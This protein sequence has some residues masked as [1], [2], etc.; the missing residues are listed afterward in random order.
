MVK[1]E[2]TEQEAKNV[3]LCLNYDVAMCEGKHK[4]IIA[5]AIKK[6]EKAILYGVDEP[7]Q[8]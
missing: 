3:L 1:I 4:R 7:E 5:S 6:M 2:L 8:K